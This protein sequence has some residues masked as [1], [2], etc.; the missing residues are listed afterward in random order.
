VSEPIILI[1][2]DWIVPVE[3]QGSVLREHDLAIQ[4]ERILELLPRAVAA[5]RHPQA[6][7]VTLPGH[8]VTPGLVNAH[9]HASMTLLR[10]VGD[11]LPLQRWLEERIWPLEGRLMSPGFVFDGAVLACE[12]MLRGGITCFNDMY[13]FPEAVA[14][15]ARALGMR[16]SLGII[17][18]D[19]PS[20]YASGP[21]DYLRKGLELRDRLGDEALTSFCLAPHAPYSV[22]D[23]ALRQVGILASE[24]GLPIH[25]HLHET[26]GEITDSVARYGV[27]PI[28]RLDALGLVGPDTIAVHAVHLSTGDLDRM[29]RRGV[30]VAHCPHSNLKLGS[31]V[32]PAAEWLERGINVAFGTDGSASNNRLDLLAEAR[33]GALLAKGVSGRAELWS[34]HELLH[35]LTLA[36]ARALGLDDRIGSLLPGKC[37][38]LVAFD[39]RRHEFQP[40]FDPVSQLIHAAGR[41]AVAEVW[42]AGKRVVQTRQLCETAAQAII[43]EVVSRTGMWQ[44]RISDILSG[45]AAL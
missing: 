27:R 10:G 30:S 37:A 25:I 12:E 24:L 8:L 16:V 5:E 40:V 6:E 15:A 42:I 43:P 38:D 20:A 45:N 39:L 7:R 28:E 9:T 26:A 2:P 14:D 13:F 11:D 32:A 1:Q 36:G 41:E 23:D 18:V 19:F 17:V 21:S 35:A 29:A 31:G 22:S 4:G 3:P 34:A 44:N 33:T